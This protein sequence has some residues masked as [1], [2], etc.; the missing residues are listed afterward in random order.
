MAA[1]SIPT[2]TSLSTRARGAI[3]LHRLR[4]SSPDPTRARQRNEASALLPS[5]AWRRARA[6]GHSRGATL[7][8]TSLRTRRALT[9]RMQTGFLRTCPCPS[10]RRPRT[11]WRGL[12]SR[13]PRKLGEARLP[14]RPTRSLSSL[15]SLPRRKTLRKCWT[16]C[17]A[18]SQVA[19]SKC[20]NALMSLSTSRR[21][22][23]SCGISPISSTES[24]HLPSAPSCMLT[25][26][27]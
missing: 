16:D 7:R 12:I 14:R 22:M 20:G 2:T 15:T 21:G 23:S 13:N 11:T 27:A 9:T 3:P 18:R 25:V 17:T 24:G 26:F 19:V 5:P 10:S 4:R 8:E 1:T 6:D